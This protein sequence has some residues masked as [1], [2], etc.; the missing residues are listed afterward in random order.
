MQ[1]SGEHRIPAPR[2][3][4]WEALHDP[5]ILKDC[6]RGCQRLDMVSDRKMAATV[7][8][9]VGPVKATFDADVE[10]VDPVA[11]ERYTLRGEGRG[12][13]AGFASGEARVSLAED[14]RD[15]ILTY[16]TDA[17][18][19][20][21]LAQLGSR[22]VDSTAKRYAAE[23]FAAFSERV[24]AGPLG[25]SPSRPME[26]VERVPSG[27]IEPTRVEEGLFEVQELAVP[28]SPIAP[29]HAEDRIGQELAEAG[30]RRV[31]GGPWFWGLLAFFAVVVL[32][33]LLS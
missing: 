3:K 12:G 30:A 11:P 32:L 16:S 22:L 8:A 23:F 26:T 9:K 25:G 13:V 5:A 2:Q 1:L 17:R 10:I 24:A 14:G 31:L 15:T 29:P 4:V 18:V 7:V 27:R 19:G 20:G 28:G 21:K 6:I 33:A